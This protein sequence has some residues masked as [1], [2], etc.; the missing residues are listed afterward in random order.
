MRDDYEILGVS[1]DATQFEIKRK[2]RRL[3]RKYHPDVNPSPS[4]ERHF[5]QVRKAYER[6]SQNAYAR[7]IAV[8]KSE[9][10]QEE[11]REDIELKLQKISSPGWRRYAARHNRV[12][13]KKKGKS[14]FAVSL[15]AI[16]I[17]FLLILAYFRLT[18]QL[19]LPIDF[20]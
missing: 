5:W 9:P 6:L 18:G 19:I 1:P 13:P 16:F 20:F 11:T 4:A 12:A 14:W 17:V 2:Y 8:S 3:A 7:E 15:L 10:E